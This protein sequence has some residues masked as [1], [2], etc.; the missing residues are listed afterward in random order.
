MKSYHVVFCSSLTYTHMGACG[1]GSEWYESDTATWRIV[2]VNSGKM[3]NFHMGRPKRKTHEL[4]Y[5]L[6]CGMR[7][8][9]VDFCCFLISLNCFIFEI[10]KTTIS[11]DL[12][13]LTLYSIQCGKYLLECLTLDCIQILRVIRI[14]HGPFEIWRSLVS[15]F[16]MN[17]LYAS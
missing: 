2:H 13:D 7:F 3:S 10:L 16:Q 8:V 6:N 1:H 5:M 12:T 17:E 11:L 15:N 4:M 14:I 9:C